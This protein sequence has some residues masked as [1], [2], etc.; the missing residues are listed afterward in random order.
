MM[1][2]KFLRALL[3]PLERAQVTGPAVLPA[4]R[5]GSVTS[6]PSLSPAKQLVRE[7]VRGDCLYDAAWPVDGE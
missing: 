5:V 4:L 3:R 2:R 6:R 1:F 7:D